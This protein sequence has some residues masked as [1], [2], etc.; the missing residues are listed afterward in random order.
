[1]FVDPVEF[2]VDRVPLTDTFALART[3]PTSLS[4]PA[5]TCAP[6]V[7]L[8][9]RATESVPPGPLRKVGTPLKGIRV[10]RLV[11]EYCVLVTQQV[12]LVAP[13][14]KDLDVPSVI[15]ESAGTDTM[16]ASG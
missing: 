7:P 3:A 8:Y 10:S 14:S 2:D 12:A 6:T 16:Q 4:A 11:K 13:R 9:H 15:D 1:M 5:V